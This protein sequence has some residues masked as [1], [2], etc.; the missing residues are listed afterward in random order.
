MG[1][2]TTEF[3][4]RHGYSV[5]FAWVFAEQLGIPVP[6]LPLLLAAGA[7]AGRGHLSFS[8]L[9]VVATIAAAVSDSLWYH[10][11][12]RKGS[13]VLNLLCRVS[14]EPDSCVR[15][16]Q[17]IFTRRGASSLL[18]AK[19][20]PG[21]G[22]VSMPLAGI[23]HMPYLTFLAY[24]LAGTVFW[25]VTLLGAGY[26]FSEQL[27]VILDYGRRSGVPLLLIAVI[28]IGAWIGLK[29]YQRRRFFRKLR[30]ARI[31]PQ[32]LKRLMD[33]GQSVFVVDLRNQLALEA[34]PMRIPGAITLSPEDL[35]GRHQEI[36]REQ[37]IVLYCT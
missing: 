27:D 26:I 18:I 15:N 16:T 8:V 30:V 36:P 3:L 6:A 10:I 11:G 34:E 23:F 17:N 13:K 37:D 28:A 12:K 5:V 2:Q 9:L 32:E 33:E 21:L 31:Y 25:V 29:Y 4:L 35:Q 24:E 14:L 22:T 7:S 1:H 20:V 19:F